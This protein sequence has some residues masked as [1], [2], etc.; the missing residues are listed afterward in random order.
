MGYQLDLSWRSSVNQSRLPTG[1]TISRFL[2]PIQSIQLE[3]YTDCP[4][5]VTNDRA[6]NDAYRPS[7]NRWLALRFR[8]NHE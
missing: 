7:F 3:N 4:E 2:L 1:Q 8:R 5:I 6:G